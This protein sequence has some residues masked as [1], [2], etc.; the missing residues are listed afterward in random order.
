[1]TKWP[2]SSASRFGRKERPH[3]LKTGMHGFRSRG[4]TTW[5][6]K[7]GEMGPAIPSSR[8]SPSAELRALMIPLP[9]RGLIPVIGIT[10]WAKVN[11]RNSLEWGQKFALDLWYVDNWSLGLDFRILA[12]FCPH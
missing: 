2:T 3:R 9:R 10:G 4:K 12:N 5:A 1:M 11:G 6:I 8:R 7:S